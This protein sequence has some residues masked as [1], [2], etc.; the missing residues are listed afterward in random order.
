MSCHPERSEGPANSPAPGAEVLRF[1]HDDNAVHGVR[2]RNVMLK[3]LEIN[4]PI[5]AQ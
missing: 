5:L 3:L 1:A 4:D 2:S